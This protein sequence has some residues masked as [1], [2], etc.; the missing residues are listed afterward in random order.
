MLLSADG[1][2]RYFFGG[3]LLS[4]IYCLTLWYANP[5]CYKYP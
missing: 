2:S 1:S 3:Y 5:L 4:A